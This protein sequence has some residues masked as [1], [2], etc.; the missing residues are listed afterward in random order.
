MPQT[1]PRS[2]PQKKV[3]DYITIAL[4][5]IKGT[6]GFERY[7]EL[8]KAF[9]YPEYQVFIEGLMFESDHTANPAYEKP[10]P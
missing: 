3:L 4:T 10:S 2:S 8:R 7:W 1:G 5:T 9:F 6:P